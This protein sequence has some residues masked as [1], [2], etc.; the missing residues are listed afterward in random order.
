MHFVETTTAQVKK[1]M[2]LTL[3]YWS[4]THIE[5]IVS[6]Y[7]S[8][9]F[10]QAEADK[11]VSRMIEQFHEDNIPVDKLIT[12]VKDGPN[13]NKA[14]M[15]K[16]KQTIKDEHPEFKGFVDLGSCV[17]HVVHNGFG[18]GLETYG[19]ETDQLCLDLHA[20]FKYSAARRED[21][22]H[23]QAN[24]GA[25]F[26]TSQQH[27]EVRWLS[28]GPAIRR[29]LE[30]WDTICHFIK[31]VEKDNIRKPKSINF[32]QAAA[33]LATGER[34][35]TSIMLGFLRSSVP[36]FEEFLCCRQVAQPYMWYMMQCV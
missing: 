25:D 1:Q 30:Q 2:D 22:Q 24:L 19:K 29:V 5:V 18:N 10:G 4:S 31:D 26:E 13:V 3:R 7:T 9:F 12:L 20:I 23:L 16:I 27:T 34:N 14:I 8:L 36:I 32:K 15:R 28:I 11:V 21:Y 33:L 35:V 6:F 17:L